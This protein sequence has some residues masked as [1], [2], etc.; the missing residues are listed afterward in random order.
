MPLYDYE[1]PQCG[2]KAEKLVRSDVGEVRCEACGAAMTRHFPLYGAAKIQGKSS[3]FQKAI[4]FPW[5][6]KR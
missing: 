2:A 3:C 5:S 1:C 6:T 4:A